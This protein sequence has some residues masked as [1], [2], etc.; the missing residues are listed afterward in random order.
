MDALINSLMGLSNFA[1][2]FFSS[3]A[4]LLIFK[5][6]YALI[7]PHDEWKLVKEDKNV[8]AAIG[9][10]GAVIGFAIAIAGAASNSVSLLDFW[11]WS[12]FALIA[13]LL[14]FAI[15][16]FIFMPKIVQS[17]NDNEISAGVVLGGFSIAVGI[18][19]AACMTY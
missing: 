13:Q 18:L 4:L 6:L 17:I 16:R 10:I 8:A 12:V 19:N 5:F 1:M 9:F 15:I 7:T 3:L 2:Y 14:A 11:L